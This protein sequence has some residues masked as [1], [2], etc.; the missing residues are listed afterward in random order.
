MAS[1]LDLSGVAKT[2][3]GWI[4][5][6]VEIVR[7]N[8]SKDDTLNPVTF[9][10][11]P[12]AATPIYA[13]RGAVLPGD[14]SPSVPDPDAQQVLQVSAGQ[15]RLLLPQSVTPPEVKAGDRVRVTTARGT[16]PDPLLTRRMFEVVDL[17]EVSSFHVG[18]FI[19]LKQVGLAPGDGDGGG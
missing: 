6:D 2:L 17:G 5:D 18:T 15:Y 10:L 12:A 9:K 14:R 19:P 16:T 4:V 7:D 3:D 13:G 8:G 11:E 1:G